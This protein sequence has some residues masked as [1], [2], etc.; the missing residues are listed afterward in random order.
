MRHKQKQY[1]TKS[2]Q[3]KYVQPF[4]QWELELVN[5][6]ARRLIGIFGFTEDDTP[7]IAQELLL[8]IFLKKKGKTNHTSDHSAIQ[9][10]VLRIA[11]NKLSA[12][13]R[14]S[15]RNK[16]AVNL[17]SESLHKTLD[18]AH[19]IE[20][21]NYE[22]ILDDVFTGSGSQTGSA[23]QKTAIAIATRKL[24]ARQQLVCR[25]TMEGK[26]VQE[27]AIELGVHRATVYGELKVIKVVF[28]REGLHLDE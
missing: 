20:E 13:I 26:S 9:K 5:K 4:E 1:R 21:V 28:Q 14:A 6:K 24:T 19:K 18:P 15:K 8:D 12:I 22:S 7:D 27:I 16:R 23:D 17:H 2:V 11:D 3:S 25:G 10:A